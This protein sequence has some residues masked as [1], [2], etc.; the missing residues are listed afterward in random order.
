MKFIHLADMHFDSC[1]SNLSDNKT[2][3]NKKR[4]E[5]RQVFKEIIEYIKE[6]DISYLFISGDL[7]ENEH[8]QET[9]IEYIN[10][11]FIQIPNTKIFISPGNH[12][13]F[14]KNSY[15]NSYNWASNVKIFGPEIEKV[16]LEEADIYGYGFDDFYC[17]DSK[18]EELEIE[19]KNK[20]N[21]LILHGTLD[22]ANIEEKQYNSMNKAMLESKGF[23]YI[24]LG[25][26][27]K[28]DYNTTKDQYIVYPGSTISMGFDEI[29]EHGVIYGEL[30]KEHIKLEFMSMSKLNFEEIKL[31]CSECYSKEELIENIKG[32]ELNK[33]RL[34]KIMLTG[35]RHFEINTYDLYNY[36]L[37]E[38]IIKIKNKTRINYNLE[39]LSNE[40]T[41]RGL[42]AKEMLNKMKEAK[43]QEE[44]E[45][46]ENAIEIGMEVIN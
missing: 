18:I 12:D 44:L 24:A 42:F 21:I 35:K 32:L 5:Q 7:Y 27:H 8:I 3:G 28:A 4:L 37:S 2:L 14:T 41:L 30:T 34:Y 40:G 16:S 11:L 17:T 25:H 39:K 10:R 6:N 22:G 26:I 23:D 46:L 15:Y 29:G 19:D 38:N 9:T 33:D 43:T 45:I 20:L 13:P 1:F 31:D 36:E